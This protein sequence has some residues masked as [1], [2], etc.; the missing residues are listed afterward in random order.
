MKRGKKMRVLEI[1][2]TEGF[3]VNNGKKNNW[4]S[5]TAICCDYFK[6]KDGEGEYIKIY[7]LTKDCP[8]P[9]TDDNVI[10]L[11]DERGRVVDW[12]SVLDE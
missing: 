5:R 7:K 10:P 4:T 11:F 12:R 8:S 1:I 9:D 6:S 3:S 2:I